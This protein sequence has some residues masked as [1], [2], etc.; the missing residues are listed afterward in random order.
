VLQKMTASD[1]EPGSNGTKVRL[2]QAAKVT[3]SGSVHNIC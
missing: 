2:H 3:R 1:I